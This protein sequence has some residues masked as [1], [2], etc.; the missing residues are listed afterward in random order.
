MR[1]KQD[2]HC[3]KSVSRIAGKVSLDITPEQL[4]IIPELN[5]IPNDASCLRAWKNSVKAEAWQCFAEDLPC[6]AGLVLALH[7]ASDG[8]RQIQLGIWVLSRST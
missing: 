5:Q 2:S 3:R 4:P 6:W 7:R 1:Q 8:Q